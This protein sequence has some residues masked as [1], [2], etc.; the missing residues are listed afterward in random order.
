MSEN[1]L[2]ANA[3]TFATL[4]NGVLTSPYSS[5]EHSRAAA[6]VILDH[7]EAMEIPMSSQVYTN[8]LTHHFDMDPPDL[9]AIEAL[10]SRARQDRRVNLDAFFFDR[11]IE[12]FARCGEVGK[13]MAALGQ[14]SKRNRVISWRAMT[15]TVRALVDFGDRMRAE[16]I[17]EAMRREDGNEDHRRS[18]TGRTTFWHTVQEL[19]IRNTDEVALS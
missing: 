7:M 6:Y 1:G 15:E 18:P 3:Y 16:E 14:A 17:V 19:G 9:A 11:L 8:L 4:V 12:G 5:G 2:D 13:M 10:F